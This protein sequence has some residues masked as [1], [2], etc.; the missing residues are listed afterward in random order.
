MPATEVSPASDSGPRTLSVRRLMGG[1]VLI[2]GSQLLSQVIG[3]VA[4]AIA[5]RKL[6]PE[7]L[8]PFAWAVGV[9]AYFALPADFGITVLAVRD[10]A[11]D[12]SKAREVMGEVL[13]LQ[14]ILGLV[15]F[16]GMVVLAP[17]IAP[18]EKSAKLLPVAACTILVTIVLGFGWA[19][20]GLQ[21]LQAI[22]VTKIVSQVIYGGL[23]VTLLVGGFEGAKRFAW[24]NVA[25]AAMLCSLCTWWA[26]RVAGRPR[27]V[28][29]R[30]RLWKR[31]RLSLPIGI[32]FAMIQIYYSLDS[33]LLGYL[34]NTGEVGQYA[35][36]YRVPLGLFAFAAIWV[37]IIY[38]H[39]SA[40][41]LKDPERLRRQVGTF[42]SYSIAIALPLGLGATFGGDGLMPKLFGSAYEASTTP[43]IL[44]V[45]AVAVSI[46]SVNF[47]N[48]LLGAGDEKRYAVGVAVG[49]VVNIAL[50][51][52]LIPPLGMAGSA[53]A[54]IAT[55]VAVVAY[56]IRRFGIV[57]GPVLIEWGR[58]LRACVA[59][60]LMSA[61]LI[62][63]PGSLDVLVRIAI[64]GV[65]YVAA[66]LA[67]GV[68]TR[69]ELR[70]I[71]R[72][73]RADPEEA[74]PGPV[75]E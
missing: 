49:A 54:T 56:M 63:L 33:V 1:F 41:A 59:G 10:V 17:V 11:R 62:V 39:A 53:I 15:V 14:T 69:S 42:A 44:L 34:R 38:P 2:S 18:D 51:F 57:L 27:L 31:L 55:E 65:V 23:V 28:L 36:A 40:M 50:N 32:S 46:V 7:N 71:A 19:L 43:F 3:F 47:G 67:L 52:V 13:V 20:R 61:V 74:E 60:A 48:V 45:W 12:P 75:P 68:V 35:V 66:A 64:G 22:A 16:A 30:Q 37:G 25:N 70:D 6:G 5:A 21:R 8:G 24:M 4:L 9:A 26:W 73:R 72:R 29:D 58:V